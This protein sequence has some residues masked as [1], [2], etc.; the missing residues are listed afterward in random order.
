M[1][2]LTEVG[3]RADSRS[4][5]DDA[6]LRRATLR[7]VSY[8]L[9]PFLALLY[10]CNYIDRTNVGIASLQMNRDLHFSAGAYGFGAGIF[11]IGYGAFEI[12][13]NLILARVGARRW[14]ARIMIT[15][16]VL[17]TGMM[18]VR[19]PLSFYVLRFL[20]GAAEAG[21]F[22]GVVYYLTSW[23]PA[24]ERARA[25][26]RFMLGVPVASMI[27]GTL[28][29]PLLGLQGTLG[30]AG[31]QWLFLLE[32]LPTIVLGVVVLGYLTES[33]EQA[34][35]LTVPQREWLV[36]CLRLERARHAQSTARD[37][38]QALR[39]R[40]VWQLGLIW[41]LMFASSNAYAF[42]AP[43]V[44]KGLFSARGSGWV[45]MMLATIAFVGGV[46]LL[47]NGAHSDWRC[48]RRQHVGVPFVFGTI[49]WLLAASALSPV[50]TLCGLGMASAS[51]MSIFGP[52]W[53][54]PSQFLTGDAA[55]GG[56]ALV[57]SLGALGAFAGPNILGVAQQLSGSQRGGFAFL[58]CLTALAATLSFRLPGIGAVDQSVQLDA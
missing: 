57:S 51:V 42:W 44:L 38:R 55:A 45:G 29:G 47:T 16:G 31:W 2:A 10:I 9:L 23:F 30:L 3:T 11:F 13:S 36:R 54:I 21:F 39:N 50:A 12:P 32:G 27:S 49:G 25:V 8:R 56:L 6:A 58:G 48:E 28:A 53:C 26:S 35:W 20:L 46:G 40:K 43:Q 7:R 5:R 14:I 4:T 24:E 19:T 1:T 34:Q 52:F 33:P 15:W 22:P 18:F 37:F 41:S 17:A